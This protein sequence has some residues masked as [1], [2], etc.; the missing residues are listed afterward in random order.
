ME[1]MMQQMQVQT[2]QQAQT[3]LDNQA[4]NPVPPPNNGGGDEE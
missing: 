2:A 3:D 1:A 4:S